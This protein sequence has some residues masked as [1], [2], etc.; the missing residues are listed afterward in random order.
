M[1][2]LKKV[3]SDKLVS[4]DSVADFEKEVDK[5][6]AKAIEDIDVAAKAKE[7]EVMSV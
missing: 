1:D 2:A 7:T 3:K 6:V 5:I 4:E